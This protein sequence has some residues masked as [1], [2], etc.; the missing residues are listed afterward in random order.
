MP[1]EREVIES[2]I[3]EMVTEHRKSIP[4]VPNKVI[5]DKSN[6]FA[7][8]GAVAVGSVC[9]LVLG[10]VIGIAGMGTAVAGTIPLGLVGSTLGGLTGKLVGQKF[11]ERT[12][13]AMTAKLLDS[14]NQVALPAEVLKALGLPSTSTDTDV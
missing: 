14:V 5:E 12:E 11:K 10:P 1:T 2:V 13:A 4:R 9:F 7:L 8:L 3:Q 6:W